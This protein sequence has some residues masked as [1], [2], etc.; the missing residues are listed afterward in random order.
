MKI[1]SNKVKAIAAYFRQELK[2]HYAQDEI[3]NFIVY[4]FEKHLGFSRIDLILKA[5]TSINESLLLRFNNIVK[6]LKQYKPIQYIL[7]EAMF[8]GI[9][10]IVNEAVLIPRQETEEL[11]RLILQEKSATKHINIL[12]IATGSGCIA[13]ALKKNIPNAIVSALDVS[14]QALAVAQAN[15]TKH[16]LDIAF[17]KADIF[18]YGGNSNDKF[19]VIVSNPPYVLASEKAMM[20]KNVLNYEPHLALFVS[21]SNALVFY[22]AISKFAKQRLNQKGKLYFE[23]NEALGNEMKILLTE[24]GFKNIVLKKDLNNKSRFIHCE[25]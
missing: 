19:D 20:H 10:L 12:D 13:I 21:D 2:S 4:A 11:L 23:I 18:T 8:Y 6:E 16:K 14:A 1:S 15:A 7:G 9:P 17:I 3:E 25:V 5:E 24:N 22:E